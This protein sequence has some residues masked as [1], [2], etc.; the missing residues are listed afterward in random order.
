MISNI[1]KYREDLE[2]LAREGDTLHLAMIKQFGQD[3]HDKTFRRLSKDNEKAAQILDSLPSFREGYQTWYSEALVLLR[4]LLPLRVQDFTRLYEKPKTK[5]K[6]ITAENYSIEDA[7]QGLTVTRGEYNP[8][9]IVGPDSA[10]PS[11]FQQVN[12]VKS[13]QKRFESSLFDIK[14]LVQADL[15]DSEL[16]V[17]KELNKKGFVRAAGAVA[18]V[19]LEGHL[20]QVCEKHELKVK[21]NHTIGALILLLHEN[22]VIDTPLWRKLQYLADLRNLCDHKKKTE[23]KTEDIEQLIAGVS[24]IIKTLF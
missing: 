14:Q 11:F 4:Q 6:E 22:E 23:P 9:T 20:V 5:R 2:H 1:D 16:E 8:Q 18:G 13:V 24:A 17:A 21:K 7:L 19:V 15:F 3:T 12:I 10:I